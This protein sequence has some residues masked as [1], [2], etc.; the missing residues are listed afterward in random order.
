MLA[1]QLD[2]ATARDA[3]H[4]AQLQSLLANYE[5]EISRTKGDRDRLAALLQ[6]TSQELRYKEEAII[7]SESRLRDLEGVLASTQGN[8]D[9]WQS[10]YQE[11]QMRFAE[12]QA[13]FETSRN[14]ALQMTEM[15]RMKDVQMAA[16]TQRFHDILRQ[17]ESELG[18]ANDLLRAKDEEIIALRSETMAMRMQP[19]GVVMAAPEMVVPAE[20]YVTETYSPPIIAAPAVVAPTVVADATYTTVSTAPY[21]ADSY[22]AESYIAAAPPII[23]PSY[24]TECVYAEQFP[25]MTET[26]IVG[27]VN[28]PP[29]TT[30]TTTY[31][32]DP[33]FNQT[34]IGTIPM[35]SAFPSLPLE[36]QHRAG[37][38]KVLVTE[39]TD[40]GRKHKNPYVLLTV[41]SH[42]THTHATKRD[43]HRHVSWNE[44]AEF[45]V[46]DA[47]TEI[48]RVSI[49]EKHRIRH[50]QKFA[51]SRPIPLA[52][53]AYNTPRSFT[54][55][56]GLGR[57]N[58]QLELLPPHG[59]NGLMNG[60]GGSGAAMG[61]TF[62]NMNMANNDFNNFNN[63][64]NA[65][66]NP[67]N[68]MNNGL[69]SSKNSGSMGYSPIHPER[70]R[71]LTKI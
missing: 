62:N 17:R 57:V 34:L 11:I 67:L 64:N 35:G 49:A 46:A 5:I 42:T 40:F 56:T 59:S 69:S 52:Q 61:N 29:I 25:M 31:T 70:S 71:D 23:T 30:T 24:A 63:F 45:D 16:E 65:G 54:A 21:L 3:T 43:R 37:R 32:L 14:A 27:P 36:Q 48:L 38:L 22:M 41:G 15:L 66:F 58:L 60:M 53:L 44:M 28:P 51:A 39:G 7:S 19:Q 2:D 4:A 12:M 50:D 68:R 8:L 20:A 10:M 33:M 1:M 26:T 9:Q 6:N 13:Q 47:S 55:D 18:Y